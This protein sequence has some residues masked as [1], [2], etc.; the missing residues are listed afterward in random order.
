MLPVAL[1]RHMIS[2]M[3]EVK[4]LLVNWLLVAAGWLNRSWGSRLCLVPWHRVRYR[5]SSKDSLTTMSPAQGMMLLSPPQDTRWWE[6]LEVTVMLQG[7]EVWFGTGQGHNTG[8]WRW[9]ARN[10]CDQLT[11]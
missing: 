5:L 10:K 11:N 6:E 4:V 1:H 3:N 9:R 2:V 7:P 8:A